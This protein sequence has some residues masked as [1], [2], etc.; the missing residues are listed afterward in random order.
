MRYQGVAQP[1]F[2]L[3]HKRLLANIEN[4]LLVEQ[5]GGFKPLLDKLNSVYVD[6]P[7][8]PINPFF[9]I[10]T[11]EQLKEAEA[12]FMSAITSND[13]PLSHDQFMRYSRHLLMDD[14]GEGGGSK[15]LSNSRVC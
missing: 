13:E 9:N 15:K 5:L 12:V 14:I 1:T 11:P 6:W 7:E 8:Q 3:W 2:S 4:A 10:N